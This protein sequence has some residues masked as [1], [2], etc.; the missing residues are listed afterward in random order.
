MRLCVC[1]CPSPLLSLSYHYLCFCHKPSCLSLVFAY[2]FLGC[3]YRPLLSKFSLFLS[4]S[5]TASNT[6]A[7]ARLPDFGDSAKAN[8]VTLSG[9]A[10]KI[11][12]AASAECTETIILL[13]F[14]FGVFY[15]FAGQSSVFQF[16]TQ[17]PGWC[18]GRCFSVKCN[19]SAA[20]LH[21]LAILCIHDY[22]L[23]S[24]S[25]AN[26]LL[27]LFRGGCAEDSQGLFLAQA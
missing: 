11:T 17:A 24:E 5:T 26:R 13:T 2:L 4:S 12:D 1:L 25:A 3:Q 19:F 14:L 21:L 23:V 15:F 9:A 27:I 7:L 22:K 16:I 8:Y 10:I 20:T 18:W 6:N